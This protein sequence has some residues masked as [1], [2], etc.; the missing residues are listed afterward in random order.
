[1]TVSPAEEHDDGT[2]DDL[3][4]RPAEQADLLAVVRIENESF[5]QPWPY[6]AFDRFLGEPGFL[7]AV[8]DAQIAGYIV[9]D[10]TTSFGRQL[11]HVKD[12]AVHPDRRDMGVGSALLSRSIAVLAAH[13]ADSIKLEVRRS[14]EGAKRLYRQFGFEPIRHVPGYYNN[15]EDAI[16]MVRQLE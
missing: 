11:G 7:V 5:S 2:D 3:V 8:V 10:V 6:D 14:N 1:M 13:G 4:I 12:I 16:I 15:G 9:S